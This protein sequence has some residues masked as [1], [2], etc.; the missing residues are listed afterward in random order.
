MDFEKNIED[1]YKKWNNSNRRLIIKTCLFIL[2]RYL[3]R[4][5]V[6]IK[7]K[8]SDN[9]LSEFFILMICFYLINNLLL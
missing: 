1:I 9:K 5:N 8:N 4:L 3:K 7:N 6:F 2:N